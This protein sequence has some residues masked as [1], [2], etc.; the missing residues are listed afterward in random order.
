MAE[1]LQHNDGNLEPPTRQILTSL[2]VLAG[3]CC[4]L[5]PTLRILATQGAAAAGAAWI[6]PVSRIAR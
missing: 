5:D 1:G 3:G 2:T 4:E 6:F